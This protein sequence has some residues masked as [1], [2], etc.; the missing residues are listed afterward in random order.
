MPL[1]ITRSIA[2]RSRRWMV[3]TNWLQTHPE[4]DTPRTLA[5]NGKAWGDPMDPEEIE[6]QA[7][8]YA[9]EKKAVKDGKRKAAVEDGEGSK[10]KK[11]K[12]KKTT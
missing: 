6:D 11:S 3:D 8:D 4:S 2:G 10:T 9:K 5:D 12:K 7:K 1:H